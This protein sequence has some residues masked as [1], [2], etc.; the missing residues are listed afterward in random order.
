MLSR[1]NE[2]TE[3]EAQGVGGDMSCPRKLF[4]DER[5]SV[6]RDVHMQSCSALRFLVRHYMKSLL[7]FQSSD[8]VGL[9]ADVSE[10][11]LPLEQRLPL[12]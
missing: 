10:D 6:F 7:F 1:E 2:G 4:L 9:H 12:V 11:R 5:N 8:G 3:R